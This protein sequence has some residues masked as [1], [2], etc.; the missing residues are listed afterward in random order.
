MVAS[1]K[2][3]RWFYEYE[4]R[5]D[6][7][8]PHSRSQPIAPPALA[9]RRASA[10]AARGARGKSLTDQQRQTLI[11][12]IRSHPHSPS[13]VAEKFQQA[14]GRTVTKVTIFQTKRKAIEADTLQL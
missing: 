13:T 1:P 9:R 4:A 10:A 5:N 6:P 14:T 8:R 3:S 12:L 2:L 7:L 11:D